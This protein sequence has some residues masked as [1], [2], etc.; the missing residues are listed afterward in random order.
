MPAVLELND[1]YCLIWMK[2]CLPVLKWEKSSIMI[3]L[4]SMVSRIQLF[5]WTVKFVFRLCCNFLLTYWISRRRLR[6]SEVYFRHF[7]LLFSWCSEVKLWLIHDFFWSVLGYDVYPA[8]M[9][10][11]ACF[12]GCNYLMNLRKF[13]SDASVWLQILLLQLE[14]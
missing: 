7:N 3:L 1:W 8:Y 5:Y 11:T 9:L 2:Q 10:N 13:H 12:N 4:E 14:D 6:L